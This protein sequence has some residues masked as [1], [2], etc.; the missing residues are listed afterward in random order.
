M[1]LPYWVTIVLMVLAIAV[2]IGGNVIWRHD[3]G[4]RFISQASG[5]VLLVAGQMTNALRSF[6]HTVERL[7]DAITALEQSSGSDP[8]RVE[9]IKSATG[10]L[11]D[12]RQDSL[13]LGAGWLL[14]GLALA[15]LIYRISVPAESIDPTQPGTPA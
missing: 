13:F 10:Y 11:A 5:M 2:L 12:L 1:S 8:G 15:H 3:R 6:E 14:V 9:A 7:G 4:A